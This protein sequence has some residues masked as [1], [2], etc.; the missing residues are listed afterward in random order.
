MVLAALPVAF[1]HGGEQV[2]HEDNTAHD[3]SAHVVEHIDDAAYPLTYFAH[4][5]HVSLMYAHI[6]FMTVA[7]VFILPVG[8]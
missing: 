2:A 5:E 6:V 7:W 1:A 8:A 4:Q 3:G